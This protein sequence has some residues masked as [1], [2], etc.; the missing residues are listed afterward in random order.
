L[1][2]T[3]AGNHIAGNHIAGNHIAG[4]HIAGNH[5]AGNHCTFY[6]HQAEIDVCEQAVQSGYMERHIFTQFC[7]GHILWYCHIPAAWCQLLAS[8]SSSSQHTVH[9]PLS[10]QRRL[11]TSLARGRRMNA[12]QPMRILFLSCCCTCFR[13]E[14]HAHM[15]NY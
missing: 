1:Q 12:N 13:S 14:A 11:S 9:V 7:Q 2:G 15:S 8:Y 5:I 4:N 6:Q 10:V 3:I